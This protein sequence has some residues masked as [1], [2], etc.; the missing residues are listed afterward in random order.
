MELLRRLWDGLGDPR[1]RL[2]LGFAGL[3]LIPLAYTHGEGF[4]LFVYSVI[5]PIVLC[6]A[7]RELE[8]SVPPKPAIVVTLPHWSF[9]SEQ[10]YKAVVHAIR[11][12]GGEV[13]E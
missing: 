9:D 5:F 7:W 1:L 12:A 10:D 2:G 13:E 4:R 3:M 6:R 8:S 11:E